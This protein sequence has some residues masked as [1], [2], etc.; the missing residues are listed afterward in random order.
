MALQGKGRR[1]MQN[2]LLMVGVLV[3]LAAQ[4]TTAAAAA[5]A[6]PDWCQNQCGNLTVPFPFG[7]D[8][9]C[10]KEDRVHWKECG[11]QRGLGH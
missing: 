2:S 7:M 3:A 11:E 4:L 5:Q 1:I 9:G 8:A 6:R 10:Y